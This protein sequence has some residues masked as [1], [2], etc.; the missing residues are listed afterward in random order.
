MSHRYDED[1]NKLHIFQLMYGSVKR[2]R[3]VNQ[4][5]KYRL[6]FTKHW[7]FL[8]NGNENLALSKRQNDDTVG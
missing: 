6:D 7:Q 3:R 8:L 1:N 4:D 2:F 5:R